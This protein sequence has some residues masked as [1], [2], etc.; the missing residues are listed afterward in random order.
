M[1]ASHS[2]SAEYC[3]VCDAMRAAV[4]ENRYL[5]CVQEREAQ[6]R[7]ASRRRMGLEGPE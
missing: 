6:E 5:R 3:Y 7:C 2:G 4:S 1:D